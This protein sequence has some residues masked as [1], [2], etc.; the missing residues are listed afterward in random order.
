[1]AKKIDPNY[2]IVFFNIYKQRNGFLLMSRRLKCSK[3]KREKLG[4]GYETKNT[5]AKAGVIGVK[6][7]LRK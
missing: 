1:M 6:A 3:M 5:R 4:E 2:R 7:D